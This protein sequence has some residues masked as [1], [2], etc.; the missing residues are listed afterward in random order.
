M[1]LLKCIGKLV[2]AYNFLIQLL[3]V[4][5]ASLCTSSAKCASEFWNTLMFLMGL[6]ALGLEIPKQ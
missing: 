5:T 6:A 3:V 4:A 1:E 2:F